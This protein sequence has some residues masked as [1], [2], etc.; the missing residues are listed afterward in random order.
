MSRVRR[1]GEVNRPRFVHWRIEVKFG[2]IGGAWVYG[3]TLVSMIKYWSKPRLYT[4]STEAVM[5]VR[6]VVLIPKLYWNVPPF[7]KS[8]GRELEE[9]VGEGSTVPDGPI[10]VGAGMDKG[11][12]PMVITSFGSPGCGK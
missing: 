4:K 10:N 2:L 1:L 9:P 12:E 11:V 8:A 7:L 5:L 3:L 6:K